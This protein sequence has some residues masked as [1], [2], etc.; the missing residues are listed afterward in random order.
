M[1]KTFLEKY[2][3]WLVGFIFGTAVVM[4]CL[5]GYAVVYVGDSGLKAVVTRIWEGPQ[6]K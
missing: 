5:V 1:E 6:D 2:L 3:P 4:A